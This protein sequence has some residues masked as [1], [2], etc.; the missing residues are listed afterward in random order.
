MGSPANLVPKDST[1]LLLNKASVRKLSYKPA[2]K[3]RCRKR[4]EARSLEVLLLRNPNRKPS[5]RALH[6]APH[7]GPAET[8]VGCE[9]TS[10]KVPPHTQIPKCERRTLIVTVKSLMSDKDLPSSHHRT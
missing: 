10:L 5:P 4:L 1:I 8:H 9:L 7:V 3:E 2:R 6:R